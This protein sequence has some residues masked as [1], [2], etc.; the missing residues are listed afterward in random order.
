MEKKKKN[1]QKTGVSALSKQAKTKAPPKKKTQIAKTTANLKA[2]VTVKVPKAA[3]K[4]VA[5]KVGAT[6]K[7]QPKAPAAKKKR[8]RKEMQRSRLRTLPKTLSQ[9]TR[10]QHGL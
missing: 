1:K 10:R 4:V 5:K 7:A 2:V 9:K 8:V 3:A 6:A